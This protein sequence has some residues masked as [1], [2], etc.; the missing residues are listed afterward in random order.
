MGSTVVRQREYCVKRKYTRFILY[1]SGGG[2]TFLL[3]D[4]QQGPGVHGVSL[5]SLASLASAKMSGTEKKKKKEG[6]NQ[7]F[8][9]SRR[10]KVGQ[11]C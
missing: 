2:G 7:L 5:A 10:S 1:P 9:I 8:R 3:N 4:F 11:S 6:L